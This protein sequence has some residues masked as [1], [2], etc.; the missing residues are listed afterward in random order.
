MALGRPGLDTTTEMLD[1]PLGEIAGDLVGVGDGAAAMVAREVG[2]A[3]DA[4]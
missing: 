2:V 4:G 1:F 3:T